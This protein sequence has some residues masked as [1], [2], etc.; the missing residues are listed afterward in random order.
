MWVEIG[1]RHLVLASP[2]LQPS[3]CSNWDV[4]KLVHTSTFNLE[5]LAVLFFSNYSISLNICMSRLDKRMSIPTMQVLSNQFSSN[6]F[7]FFMYSIK[8][9]QFLLFLLSCL[10]VLSLFTYKQATS[11]SY[12]RVKLQ[13]RVGFDL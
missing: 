2:E 6:L 1:G 11:Y 3:V 10:T 5:F 8:F 12:F 13:Q 4:L 7:F 9:C